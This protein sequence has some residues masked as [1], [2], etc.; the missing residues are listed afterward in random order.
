VLPPD[1]A[2]AV[3]G[4]DTGPGNVLMDGWIH[5]HQRQDY[6]VDGQWAASGYVHDAL[7]EQCLAD[8][9]LQLPAPKSTGREHYHLGWLDR[10]LATVGE[11]IA[12]VD[13]QAT[14]C[15]FTAQTITAAIH[16]ACGGEQDVA[17][18]VCGGGAH[19]REL[20]RRLTLTL[21]PAAVQTTEALGIAPKWVEASAFAWLAMRTLQG[22]AGNI[23]SVTGAHHAVI[24][25]GIYPGSL[26]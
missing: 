5:L 10:Q 18:Y 26:R 24:L 12:P 23:P 3:T 13:V 17:V 14:L 4:F 8:P 22:Q 11:D 20:L 21:R 2:Q 15:E 1:P 19:N 16:T 7:L 9:Y 25:G 6:D